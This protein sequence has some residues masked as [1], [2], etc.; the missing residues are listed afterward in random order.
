[1]RRETASTFN[2]ISPVIEPFNEQHD[3]A[4]CEILAE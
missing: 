2:E 3:G 1:M 4:W